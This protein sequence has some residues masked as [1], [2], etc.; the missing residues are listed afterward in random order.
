VA[1]TVVTSLTSTFVEDVRFP[2]GPSAV[3][4]AIC[5]FVPPL[6]N[7]GL[8]PIATR[9]TAVDAVGHVYRPVRL[10]EPELFVVTDVVSNAVA[11]EPSP[12]LPAA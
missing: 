4:M 7:P 5:G 11:A 6:G 9:N 10:N 3:I 8:P 12:L 2:H 1:A